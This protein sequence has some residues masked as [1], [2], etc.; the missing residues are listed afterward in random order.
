VPL[1]PQAQAVIDA[2]MAAGL[3]PIFT[4]TGTE[5]RARAKARPRA[6][7]PA[8]LG[9]RQEDRLVPA[10]DGHEIPIRVYS[11]ERRAQPL[12]L[13]VW[14]HGGGWVTGDLDSNDA[15]CHLLA[16]E[17]GAVVVSV[18]YRLAPEHRFPTAAEDAYAAVRWS[19]AQAG[20]LGADSELLAVGGASAGGNLAAA[21]ALMARDREGPSLIHQ[22]LVY[23][24]T[25]RDFTRESY[26]ENGAGFGLGRDAME[27]YWKQYL[28]DHEEAANPY[29]APLQCGD[30][31][32]LPRAHVLTAEYDPLRD[33]GEEYARC[34]EEQGVMTV[35][36][37]YPG[38]IHGFFGMLDAIDDAT[39]AIQEAANQLRISGTMARYA[40]TAR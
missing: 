3:P 34:L 12:P 26:I 23:P 31:T 35:M 25:D 2:E 17:A 14:Y 37:R 27:W 9:V 1:H 20:E 32:R 40:A 29:A 7:V 36:T 10:A 21:V 39:R 19:A 5:A 24:V 33:E 38:M 8:S 11:P 18:D 30:L 16:H 22:L 28:G 4:L 6:A 13:L 15:I